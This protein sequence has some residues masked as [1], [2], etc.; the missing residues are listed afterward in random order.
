LIPYESVLVSFVRLFYRSWYVVFHVHFKV[1]VEPIFSTTRILAWF[2]TQ[3]TCKFFI[4]IILYFFLTLFCCDFFTW[5]QQSLSTTLGLGQTHEY[6]NRITG[7]MHWHNV[8]SAATYE[9]KPKP[10]CCC[11]PDEEEDNVNDDSIVILTYPMAAATMAFLPFQFKNNF[12]LNSRLCLFYS[13]E[14]DRGL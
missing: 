6:G 12:I 11:P 9:T 3:L 5:G 8:S 10:C 13:D 14:A 4:R 1:D 2:R 7:Y